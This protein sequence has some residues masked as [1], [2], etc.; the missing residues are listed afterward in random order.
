MVRYVGR[1]V[2]LRYVDGAEYYYCPE[3]G[4]LNVIACLLGWKCYA[5]L[6]IQF[7]AVWLWL[8]RSYS[9]LVVLIE[10]MQGICL[11]CCGQRWR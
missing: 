8:R 10:R 6:E 4:Y 1:G 2:H 9:R 7:V 11:G 3:G 5:I